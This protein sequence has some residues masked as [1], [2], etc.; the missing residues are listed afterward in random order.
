M[1]AHSPDDHAQP[2]TRHDHEGSED[3]LDAEAPLGPHEM[4]QSLER[5]AERAKE[6]R[7]TGCSCFKA[8]MPAT[9]RRAGYAW[10]PYMR[11]WSLVPTIALAAMRILLSL[12]KRM[13]TSVTL[14]I[15]QTRASTK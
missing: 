10:G 5:V 15:Q 9:A 8:V 13:N 3:Q 4:A 6:G 1:T 2:G 14:P 11:S 12:R 7:H